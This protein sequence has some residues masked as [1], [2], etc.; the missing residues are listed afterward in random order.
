MTNFSW[1][2][3]YRHLGQR[4]HGLL[5]AADACAR[6]YSRASLLLQL[7]FAGDLG[8]FPNREPIPLVARRPSVGREEARQRLGLG[9]EP[10][11]LLSFG[12]IGMPG[13]DPGV[14]AALSRY[15]FLTNGEWRG[16]AANVIGVDAAR[17]EAAGLG[18]AELVAAADVVVT[19]P[20]YG[21]VTDA[22][23]AGTRMIYTDRGD[24]P[25][26]PVMVAE[27][28]RYLAC[29]YVTNDD[30]R[31]GRLE[32]ALEAVRA[33]PQPPLPDL[34]GADVAARRLLS[35]LGSK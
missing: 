4:Y 20:G 8:A 21:I 22:I 16:S 31:A 14:V 9:S 2:W 30:V 24:F 18:Y 5:E 33:M 7:P 13:F 15:T 10:H 12:G 19:K 27:M 29:A 6:S 17:L 32:P 23:G 1:D 25:E 11:V 3:I 35:L 34:S 28:G 26:Y